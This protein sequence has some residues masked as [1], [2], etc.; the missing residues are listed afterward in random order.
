M[1]TKWILL[2]VL[3]LVM[4]LVGAPTAQVRAAGTVL[5]EQL[6]N[7]KAFVV[8]AVDIC[9][10]VGASD[11]LAAENFV[12]P[13]GETRTIGEI[14]LWGTF[15]GADYTAANPTGDSYTVIFYHPDTTSGLPGEGF[16]TETA[17]T[18]VRVPTG[19][20]ISVTTTSGTTLTF[21]EYKISLTLAAPLTLEAG[22]YWIEIAEEALPLP[23]VFAWETGSV[24]SYGLG[25]NNWAA[26]KTAYENTLAYWRLMP[27]SENITDPDC[28]NLALRLIEPE[29]DGE[30]D[31]TFGTDGRVDTG[32]SDNYA[33]FF[34]QAPS[35][36]Q[37]DG[38]ILVGGFVYKPENSALSALLE[39]YTA[40]GALDV[41]FGS[42]GRLFPQ[43]TGST[44][45]VIAGTHIGAEDEIL[46]F[47]GYSDSS[48]SASLLFLARYDSAGLP[49]AGF[50][51]DGIL[52]VP[53]PAGWAGALPLG[54]A[55]Q[56]DGKLLITGFTYQGPIQVGFL[57]RLD[58]A[59]GTLDP[60]FGSGGVALMENGLGQQITLLSDGSILVSSPPDWPPFTIY[61]FTADGALDVTFDTDGVLE[62][63][64]SFMCSALAEGPEGTLYLTA[65]P[66]G[67]NYDSD[68]FL[69]RMNA[70]GSPDMTFGTESGVFTDFA[71]G[72]DQSCS[73]LVQADGNVIVGGEAYDAE[74]NQGFALVRY[75]ADGALDT[76]FGSDGKIFTAAAFPTIITQLA[77][78]PAGKLLATGMTYDSSTETTW[79]SLLRYDLGTVVPTLTIGPE[80][81]AEAYYGTP[82][83]QEFTAT[84]GTEPYTFSIEFTGTNPFGW[85]YSFDPE[86]G[87]WTLTGKP[88]LI[89]DYNFTISATD[90]T[91]DGAL[92]ASR[93][94]TLHIGKAIPTVSLDNH[95]VLTKDQVS[96]KAS[97]EG[98]D[99]NGN[100]LPL[101]GTVTYKLDDQVITGCENISTDNSCPFTAPATPGEYTLRADF[102]PT[103][104][105]LYESASGTATQTVIQGYQISGSVFED[106]NY[107][108][109]KDLGEAPMAN[110]GVK[111]TIGGYYGP[112][113]F[114][115]ENGDYS[116]I[117]P[118]DQTIVIESE[119]NQLRYGWAYTVLPSQIDLLSSDVTGKDIGVAP[120]TYDPQD[121]PDGQVGTA[122]NQVVTL[123]GGIGPF[124]IQY[125]EGTTP[126]DGLT[127][128]FDTT[129]GAITIHGTPTT[130]GDPFIDAYVTDKFGGETEFST[131]YIIA[132]DPLLTLTSSLNPSMPGDSVTF[133]LTGTGT[134]IIPPFGTV[135]FSDGATVLCQD[136]VLNYFA[137]D[138]ADVPATCTTSAL[139]AGT[140][141]ITAAFTSQIPFYNSITKTLTQVVTLPT[142][143]DLSLTKTDSKDPIKPGANLTYTLTVKNLGPNTAQ[144][145]TLVDTLDRDTTYGSVSAP[146]GWTCKYANYAVTCTGTSLTSGSSATIKITVTVNKTAKV[147]KDLVN[148]ATVSSQ[149]YDPVII[150]NSAVQKTMV[151]K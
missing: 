19:E 44:A 136:V 39:R 123:K 88:A 32:V 3:A 41:S 28:D 59:D 27:T 80:T 62:I 144:T 111:F 150:N 102:T 7:Q 63:P 94:Y 83:M 103:A 122:Y 147:G 100:I 53:L 110:W 120:F 86:T 133:T 140:H 142:S 67:Q 128:D 17:L 65:G 92:Q 91:T 33:M 2:V 35:V 139:T 138:I 107:N 36:Q 45:S 114:T 99:E 89:G 8:A 106:A 146:K 109:V 13:V 21:P 85:N 118:A 37:S 81:I 149:T 115:D 125:M 64:A 129:T 15:V 66:Y 40:D 127:Y 113:V 75:T 148:N 69:A 126:P 43:V 46:A 105:T 104:N 52:P 82:Y 34:I 16:H 96:V 73:L 134:A 98:P 101:D 116:A 95:S 71:G 93:D 141:T 48:S 1:K 68:F 70:D 24:D 54:S 143:A 108:K 47:G 55:L 60:T 79:T 9:N 117:L 132:G 29:T 57:M 151:T 23:I 130:P 121:L 14:Q 119:S 31:L 51:T 20:V 38:S 50:G 58:P 18:P 78:T 12:V 42:D 10:H 137:D 97:V 11:C 84:G 87:T 61:R 22:S 112:M 77:L 90:S 6:P 131:S 135:T 30:L 76:S 72:D 56:S 26:W 145:I 124:T 49:V 74:Y 4:M 25:Q 5:L